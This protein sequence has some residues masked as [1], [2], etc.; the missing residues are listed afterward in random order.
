VVWRAVR[1]PPVCQPSVTRN[2][3][4]LLL[5][6]VS[7]F[8]DKVTLLQNKVTLFSDKVTLLPDKVS[9]PEANLSR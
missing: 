3:V 9:L 5:N 1:S 4:T 7:L 8:S 6:K 2:K